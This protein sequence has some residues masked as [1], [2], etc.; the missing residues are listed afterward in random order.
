MSV[1]SRG[2]SSCAR[3]E[4]RSPWSVNPQAIA[5]PARRTGSPPRRTPSCPPHCPRRRRRAGRWPASTDD[6]GAAGAGFL[7]PRRACRRLDPRAPSARHSRRWS[8]ATDEPEKPATADPASGKPL[9][10]PGQA[11]PATARVGRRRRTRSDVPGSEG[12]MRAARD[13]VRACSAPATASSRTATT[14]GSRSST[15]RPA[16]WRRFTPAGCASNSTTAAASIWS[17]PAFVDT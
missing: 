15:D 17:S 13:R 8:S 1:R 11:A 4:R 9:R 14:G 10:Q 7:E 2:Q 5:A 16:R 6:S 3:S 12:G